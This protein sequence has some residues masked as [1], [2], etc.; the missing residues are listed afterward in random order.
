M[1]IT[2]EY[3]NNCIEYNLEM[4]VNISIYTT[5]RIINECGM[6][7]TILPSILAILSLLC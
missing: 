6:L 1:I 5:T 4:Q 7:N 3:K 2:Y